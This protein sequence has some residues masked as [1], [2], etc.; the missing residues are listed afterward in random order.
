[1]VL[2]LDQEYFLI[3]FFLSL[4]LKKTWQR[5]WRSRYCQREAGFCSE[6]PFLWGVSDAAARSLEVS[7]LQIWAQGNNLANDSNSAH[8]RPPPPAWWVWCGNAQTG[9]EPGMVLIERRRAGRVNDRFF[10]LSISAGL[11]P[12]TCS[13]RTVPSM[14]EE[15]IDWGCWNRGLWGTGS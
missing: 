12:L 10:A 2:L 14:M 11:P 7:R 5:E 1:M 3:Q 13:G 8:R 9:P 15:H 6:T 4:Q